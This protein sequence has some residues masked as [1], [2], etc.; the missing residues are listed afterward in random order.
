MVMQKQPEAAQSIVF[1][2]D[3]DVS[4]REALKSPLRS[5]RLCVEVFDSTAD[6]LKH[7]FADDA[8]ACVSASKRARN[9]AKRL[10]LGVAFAV[11]VSS[12]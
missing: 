7:K 8:A 2:V 10:V 1:V 3:D 6:F 9:F 11:A 5:V 4:L 12:T